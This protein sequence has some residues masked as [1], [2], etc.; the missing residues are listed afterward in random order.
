MQVSS[1]KRLLA[2]RSRTKHVGGGE[3]IALNSWRLTKTAIYSA[4]FVAVLNRGPAASNALSS[5][6][7]NDHISSFKTRIGTGRFYGGFF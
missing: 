4:Y 3:M 2:K 5:P 6:N 1:V 7:T